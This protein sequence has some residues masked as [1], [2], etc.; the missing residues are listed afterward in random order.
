MNRRLLIATAGIMTLAACTQAPPPAPD[1]RAADEKALKDDEA[2][3]NKDWESKDVDKIVSHYADE[4]AVEVPDL[5]ISKDKDGTKNAIKQFVG[6][7]S[8]SFANDKIDV[9]KGGDLAYVQGHY[10]MTMTDDKTKKKV[11]EKG[12]YVTIYKKQADG[13]WK[14][15]QDINNRDAPAA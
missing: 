15:V 5:P 4:A 6:D 11:T 13:A 3:W 7:F 8:I 12:K 2:A 10:S 14:A 1:T 9:S